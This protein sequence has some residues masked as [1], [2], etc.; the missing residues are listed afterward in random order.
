MYTK[1]D[2]LIEYLFVVILNKKM[3]YNLERTK[4]ERFPIKLWWEV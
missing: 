4:I 1:L 2:M 3:D